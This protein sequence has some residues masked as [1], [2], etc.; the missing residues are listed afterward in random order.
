MM[1]LIVKERGIPIKIQQLDA[2]LR[3]IKLD[4]PSRT[5]IEDVRVKHMT[6]F[7][8]EESIDYYLDY[9]SFD[10]HFIL[11]DLRLYGKNGHYFQIDTLILTGKFIMILEIKN[12]FGTL[13]F[14]QDFHQLL[15]FTNDKEEAFPDPILQINEQE[16]QLKY[17]LMKNKLP[18]LPI[19]SFVVISKYQTLLK[20]S[21]QHK[22]IFQKIIRPPVISSKINTLNQVHVNEEIS[23]EALEKIS[24]LLLAQ[25]VP[26]IQNVIKQFQ[27]TESEII[28]GIFCP[29]C[30]SDLIKKERGWSC[31]QCR[32]SYRSVPIENLLDYFFL[33]RQTI[34][35]RQARDFFQINSRI[36][37]T[38]FLKSLNLTSTGS[39]KDCEYI[40]TY[41]DLTKPHQ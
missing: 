14:D 20:T 22:G 9:L 29:E 8:G 10:E 33:V 34:T 12:I 35:N 13:F 3:R 31:P 30:F 39:Y 27:I 26:G 37:V 18:T 23:K 41:F 40:L 32:K 16:A 36:I 21:P 7:R 28:K 6:G 2:L 38:K 24:N 25:Y 11:H 5:K 15:R 1:I 4:H 17:W 19:A